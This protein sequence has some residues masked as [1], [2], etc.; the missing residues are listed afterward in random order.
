MSKA[1]TRHARLTIVGSGPAGYTAA[2][3]AARALLEPVLIAGFEPGGQLMITTDVE[4]YPGFAAPIQGPWLMEQ[5]RLRPSMSARSSSP[6]I[7]SRSSW[8]AVPSP[9]RRQ[10]HDPYDRCADHRDRRQGALARH[11]DG[12]DLSRLRRFGLRHLRRIFLSRQRRARR[13]RRQYRGRG[14]AL[15]YPDHRKVTIVHRRDCFAPRRFCRIGC[16]TAECRSHLGQC[17]R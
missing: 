12:G 1:P 8:A 15:S 9:L 10:R 13:R 6:I 7:S 5:M 2:I 3:Y 16:S 4:N 14:S 11:P 17:R